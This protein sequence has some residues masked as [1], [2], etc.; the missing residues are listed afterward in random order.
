MNI[1]VLTKGEWQAFELVLEIHRQK[2]ETDRLLVW[3]DFSP[4]EWLAGMRDIAEVKQHAA[5]KNMSAH[6]NAVK[7]ELP[8][9][10]WILMLDADER[11][12]PSFLA[13]LRA[14]ILAHP[15]DDA[16]FLERFN[17]NWDSRK[18]VVPPVEVDYSKPFDPDYQPRVFRN[19]ASIRFKGVV[20]EQLEGYASVLY[21]SGPPYTIIH[22]RQNCP[23]R[24]ENFVPDY[25]A[26][27]K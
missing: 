23:R 26:Y 19:L 5:D 16:M 17:F 14:N 27:L 11:I 8:E 1:V 21:L 6:R 18:N 15:E 22:H 4:S 13:A 2:L 12:Q 24:Y 9:G 7:R 20:H 3:D 10:E 25:I